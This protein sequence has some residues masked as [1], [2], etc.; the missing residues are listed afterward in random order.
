MK[1]LK[2]GHEMVYSTCSILAEENEQVVK[3]VLQRR[4]AKILPIEEGQF[5][6]VP[7]LPT[8]LEGTM[9]VCPD[10]LYE[11]FFMARLQKL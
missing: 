10:G 9:C 5:P 7:L 11:G 6:G 2:P 3:R 1:H 4:G 8:E